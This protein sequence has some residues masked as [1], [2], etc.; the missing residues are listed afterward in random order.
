MHRESF[1]QKCP[2]KLNGLESLTDFLAVFKIFP[3]VS[4]RLQ[5]RKHQSKN[6]KTSKLAQA[7]P[8]KPGNFFRKLWEYAKIY[9]ILL[10]D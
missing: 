7:I 6:S 9:K 2:E 4:R 3:Y 10:F 5:L 8:E 1:V